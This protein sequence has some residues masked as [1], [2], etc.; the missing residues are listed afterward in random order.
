MK[1]VE[2]IKI[3]QLLGCQLLA[4]L[5]LRD[6][7]LSSTFGAFFGNLGIQRE[8]QCCPEGVKIVQSF[9]EVTT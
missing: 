7:C 1:A 2:E 9:G 3:H 5:L 8:I 4:W 6:A